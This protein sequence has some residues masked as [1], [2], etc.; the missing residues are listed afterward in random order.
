MKNKSSD[1]KYWF[2]GFAFEF[3]EARQK[4]DCLTALQLKCTSHKMLTRLGHARDSGH[5]NIAAKQFCL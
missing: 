4:L 1:V 5:A 2:I 3:D